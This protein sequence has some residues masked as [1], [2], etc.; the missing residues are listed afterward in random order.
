MNVFM[1]FRVAVR[2]IWRNKTR[3]ALTMLGIIFGIAAVIMVLAI[4]KGASSNM[5]AQ[6]AKMGDNVV[7][8]FSEQ[9]HAAA[10]VHGGAGEG[11]SLTASDGLAIRRELSHL[12]KAESPEVRTQ[13]QI[14]FQFFSA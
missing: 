7:M 10:G 13:M 6:I 11:Q 2:A 4:G 14:V 8:I 12:V 5:V 1:I 9:R 3:S